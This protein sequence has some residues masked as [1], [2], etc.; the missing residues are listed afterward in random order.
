M[1][2]L[3]GLELPRGWRI[4]SRLLAAWPVDNDH[5]LELWPTGRTED[6][7]IRWQYRLSRQNHTIFTGSDVTSGAG[8]VFTA[9]ELVCAA[10]T[11]LA[12]LTLQEGDTDREYFDAYTSTQI[13]WRDQYAEELSVHAMDDL[14]GYCGGDHLS[15]GCP[16]RESGS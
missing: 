9:A 10:R 4:S 8:V 7:R 11:V 12:Y 6:G 14:C 15:P 13:A 2:V 5:Q 1:P 16:N 3:D